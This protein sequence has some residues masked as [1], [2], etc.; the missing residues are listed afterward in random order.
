MRAI[1]ILAAL[2]LTAG[3]SYAQVKK[4]PTDAFEINQSVRLPGTP[5]EIFGAITGDIGGWWDHSFSE[6]PKKF[7]LEP[8]VGGCF[9]EI[10]DEKGNGVQHAVVTY[11]DRPKILRFQGP[12]GLAGNAIQMVCTYTFEPVGADSTQLTLKAQAAGHVE[13]GWPDVVA[14]VWTHFL[15]EQF[16]PY[17]EQGKHKAKR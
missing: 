14:K 11:V 2:M 12:L 7:Y 17:V 4:L 10:F 1:A 9:C 3:A 6:N 16:K 8:K 15:V 13:P 5:E